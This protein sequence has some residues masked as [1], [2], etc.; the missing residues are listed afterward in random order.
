MSIFFICTFVTYF[1]ISLWTCLYHHLGH[2]QCDVL[3][4]CTCHIK[5]R[6]LLKQCIIPPS[7]VEPVV[8]YNKSTSSCWIPTNVISFNAVFFT[9]FN[10]ALSLFLFF[11]Y[12]TLLHMKNT[13]TQVSPP[14]FPF[15]PQA[16]L[17]ISVNTLQI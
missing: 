1:T 15:I 17:S 5:R 4:T 7:L 8:A 11:I 16:N 2:V 13:I 6:Q 3:L 14:P 10:K 9:S 12:L